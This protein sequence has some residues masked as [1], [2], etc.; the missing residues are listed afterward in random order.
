MLAGAVA[1][2]SEHVAMYPMDTIKTRMQ[3]LGH[4]GQRVRC[5]T[6]SVTCLFA[7]VPS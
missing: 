7:R 2:I 5:S 3:A 1:G 6:I 4:P